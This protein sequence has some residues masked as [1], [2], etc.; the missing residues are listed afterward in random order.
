ML[1]LLCVSLR[2]SEVTLVDDTKV[3]DSIAF[4]AQASYINVQRDT[5]LD[6]EQRLRKLE[7]TRPA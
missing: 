6:R 7:G 1:E 5:A 3:T 4:I 2:R